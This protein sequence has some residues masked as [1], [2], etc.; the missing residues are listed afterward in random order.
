MISKKFSP[1]ALPSEFFKGLFKGLFKGSE[2]LI[3]LF[4]G[5]R[6]LE[7]SG[8]DSWGARFKGSDP[9]IAGDQGL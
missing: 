4:Q 2:P 1:A 6:A 3:R 8:L 9:L 7:P 5:V